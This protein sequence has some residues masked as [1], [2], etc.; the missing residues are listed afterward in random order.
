[1]LAG[2][3]GKA[4]PLSQTNRWAG[5]ETSLLPAVPP[6][7]ILIDPLAPGPLRQK[8]EH[9]FE[10]AEE[11]RHPPLA[12]LEQQRR[13]VEVL[14][15]PFGVRKAVRSEAVGDP[16]R[17]FKAAAAGAE[18]DQEPNR[19]VRGVVEVV[20]RVLRPAPG[21]P[22]R[23]R[24]RP[25]PP[26]APLRQKAGGAQPRPSWRFAASSC[27]LVSVSR[28]LGSSDLVPFALSMLVL[29]FRADTFCVRPRLVLLHSDLL[30]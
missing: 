24:P 8:T 15:Q 20:Q 2:V 12:P 10:C 4:L 30:S 9:G 14:R 27:S 6:L 28:S 25:L 22:P 3:L 7:Q 17:L 21:C 1:M 5:C 23:P 19:L 11:S 13:V 29:T 26:P 16:E 18:L